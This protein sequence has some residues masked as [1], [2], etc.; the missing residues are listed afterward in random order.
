M[1][2]WWIDAIDSGAWRY[3]AEV[4]AWRY[5]WERLEPERELTGLV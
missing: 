5:D 4:A 1:V 2:T 3:D